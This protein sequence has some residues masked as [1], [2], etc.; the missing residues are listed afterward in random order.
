[1]LAK[2][3]SATVVGIEG[4]LV[5]VECDVSSGA[6]TFDTI[7]LPELAVREARVRVR[8]AIRHSELPFP[9]T[10][11]IV[12][13]APADLRKE[14]TGYDLPVALGILTASGVLPLDALQGWL[15]IGE[16]S[17]T[18]AIRPVS[19]VLPPRR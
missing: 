2:I 11:V 4:R 14:G 12:N 3:Q 19:G 16:L 6:P 18:G 17:L 5:D 8:S 7:G 9:K 13:L 10:R 1:M 15:V